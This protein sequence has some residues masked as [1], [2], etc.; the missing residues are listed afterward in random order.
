MNALATIV[1][2][3]IARVLCELNSLD[4]DTPT[5]SVSSEHRKNLVRLFSA[6]PITVSRLLGADK[7]VISGGGVSLEEIDFKTMESKIVPKLFIV[8][9]VL[10]IDR[11]SGGYSLQL[12][13]STGF[14]AGENC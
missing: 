14:I 8:G 10:D 12:C 1:P 11:P 6:L 9:D 13:W 3:A 2:T 4:E 7:A 5:H